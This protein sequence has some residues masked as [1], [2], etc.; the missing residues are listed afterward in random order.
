MAG[1][2]PDSERLALL[3]MLALHRAGRRAEAL[4]AYSAVWAYLVEAHGVTPGPELALMRQRI[5]GNDPQLRAE[6][7]LG[8]LW[9]PPGR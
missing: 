7:F 5:D 8:P 2:H 9:G 3:H 6:P 4:A 1:R